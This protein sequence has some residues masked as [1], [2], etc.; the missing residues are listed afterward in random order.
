MTELYCNGELLRANVEDQVSMETEQTELDYDQDGNLY[1]TCSCGDSTV[2]HHAIAVLYAYSETSGEESQLRGAVDSAIKQRVQRGRNE[3]AVKPLKGGS[4]FG[5]WSAKSIGSVGR[6]SRSYNVH[7]RSLT[8]RANYC[9]CPDFAGNQLGTCKHIE[10]VL[11]KIKKKQGAVKAKQ[12][13]TPFAYIYLDWNQ[14]DAP[15][16]AL[17]RPLRL[18]TSLTTLLDD[19]FDKRGLFKGRLP[20]DFFRLAELLEGREDIDLGEDAMS[21]ARRFADDLAHLSRSRA[22]HQ[23]IISSGGRLP[24]INAKLYPYQVEGVAF[25]AANGR[26]RFS[27]S[28]GWMRRLFRAMPPHGA[29]YIGG[30]APLPSS[31]MSWCYGIS[32]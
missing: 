1:V 13:M 22:I 2:C 17:H 25:L 12:Q 16:I 11:H 19:Y 5:I 21:Y 10:A 23:Q 15:Q 24:G 18:T 3:V 29:C 14:Q 4:V 28:A 8:Q 30:V 26:V 20:D 32:R 27:A 7:I 6:L 31:I 9:S